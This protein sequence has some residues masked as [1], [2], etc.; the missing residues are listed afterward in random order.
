MKT[1]K[2]D[3]VRVKSKLQEEVDRVGNKY[4]VIFDEYEDLDSSREQIITQSDEINYQEQ[5]ISDEEIV[6]IL[7]DL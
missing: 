2:L 1:I 3:D 4:N 7:R 5:T 6:N